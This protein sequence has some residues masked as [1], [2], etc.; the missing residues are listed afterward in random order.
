MVLTVV[1][2]H[3]PMSVR[4]MAG[5][6]L[7]EHED[8]RLPY[9]QD[10]LEVAVENCL[11]KGWLRVLSRKIVG[12]QPPDYSTFDRYNKW[13]PGVMDF[14]AEGFALAVRIFGEGN[15]GRG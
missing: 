10:D 15:V 13:S 4:D 14:T 5:W 6:A 8:L 2:Y 1:H 12:R 7:K 11:A 9:S 3:T